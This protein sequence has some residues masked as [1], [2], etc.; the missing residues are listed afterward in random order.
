HDKPWNTLENHPYTA[1]YLNKL[2]KVGARN[3]K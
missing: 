2:K 3:G 1:L